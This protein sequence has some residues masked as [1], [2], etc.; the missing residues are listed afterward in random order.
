MPHHGIYARAMV[1][2]T[3]DDGFILID[4]QTMDA[5]VEEADLSDESPAQFAAGVEWLPERQLQTEETL[6]CLIIH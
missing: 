4:E 1:R 2:L 3:H 6:L 5:T